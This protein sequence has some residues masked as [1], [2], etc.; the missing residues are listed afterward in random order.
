MVPDETFPP[1]LW[2]EI[3]R[4]VDD[5]NAVW[6]L[7]QTGSRLRELVRV[8]DEYIAKAVLSLDPCIHPLPVSYRSSAQPDVRSI[9]RWMHAG[10]VYRRI[11]RQVRRGVS[12]RL[13]EVDQQGCY[14]NGQSEKEDL[15]VVPEGFHHIAITA[16]YPVGR[17]YYARSL[18]ASKKGKAV[19]YIDPGLRQNR[20]FPL[21]DFASNSMH[22]VR[23][24]EAN[25]QDCLPDFQYM[26]YACV[27]ELDLEN[28][29]YREYD[30]SSCIH[31]NL[32]R[33]LT[34]F[35]FLNADDDLL[36][37][38]GA[39]V[40]VE[41]PQYIISGIRPGETGGVDW[42]LQIPVTADGLGVANIL[43]TNGLVLV[44]QDI[45]RIYDI[46]GKCEI[47]R[48][49]MPA[50]FPF[51]RFS[52]GYLAT[53]QTHLLALHDTK[54]YCILISKLLRHGDA[55]LDRWDVLLDFS[56]LYSHTIQ[57]RDRF[58]FSAKRFYG[59]LVSISLTSGMCL[60]DLIKGT[61]VFFFCQ[62]PL[63]TPLLPSRV[64]SLREESRSSMDNWVIDT[65]GKVVYV[66]SKMIKDAYEQLH[67]TSSSSPISL[68][69]LVSY[70]SQSN[71]FRI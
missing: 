7:F 50:E 28:S 13:V 16:G 40:G 21:V 41:W 63:R 20:N 18:L 22:L 52:T 43:F 11:C 25:P 24:W 62:G 5:F 68:N 30:L 42:R 1:E 60:I 47:T 67:Q 2:E 69:S 58:M 49:Q 66:P 64:Y 32:D 3:I 55:S 12:G 44:V 65:T 35:C 48:C 71:S 38:V 10:F 14:I 36:L 45:L 61:S 27:R 54:V 34:N 23:D 19:F 33:H 4:H 59:H 15:R 26:N 57:P 31:T 70:Q 39:D 53:T 46:R 37:H 51:L 8:N 6:A 17:R 56:R 9:G 29:S